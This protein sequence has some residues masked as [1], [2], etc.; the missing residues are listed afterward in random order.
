MPRKLTIEEFVNRSRELYGAKYDYSKVDYVNTSTK[1]CITCKEHGDFWITPSNFLGGHKC[2]ACSGRER[3]TQEVFIKRSELVHNNRY[4]YSK[5]DY[6]GLNKPV[7]IICPEHGEFWQKANG[8]M[9][10]QG[11][12]ICGGSIKSL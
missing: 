9:Y 1:V 7:C 10:G 5:V 3:I 12:P 6:K 11:C 8:H 4:D 2:P